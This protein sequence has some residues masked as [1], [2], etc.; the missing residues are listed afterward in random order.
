MSLQYQFTIGGVDVTSYVQQGTKI[1]RTRQNIDGNNALI[2]V[3]QNISNV[4]SLTLGLPIII[5]RGVNAV[6]EEYVFRGIIKSLKNSNYIFQL[7]CV[8]K[9]SQLKL[10]YFTKSY[11]RN[12]DTEEGVISAIFADI[13]EG[14]GFIA[15]VVD[16]SSFPK[17]NKLIC[18]D[19]SRLLKLD[20]LSTFLNWHFYHDYEND[21]IRFEP[22]NFEEYDIDLV[23]GTNI[24]S[25][26]EWD[27]GLD[28]MRN[29]IKILGA[30]DEDTRIEYFDGD[31]TAK[32]F[33]LTN[34]PLIT[35]V[36]YPID[37]LLARGIVGST[38]NYDY[39]IDSEQNTITFVNAPGTG[40]NNIKVKYTTKI[41]RPV[42]GKDD[43]SISF[44]GVTQGEVFSFSD[45]INIDD[46]ENRLQSLLSLLSITKASTGFQTT[47]IGI[48][49]G[50]LVTVEDVNQPQYNGQYTVFSSII[51][52]KSDFDAVVI[53]ERGF[54]ITR[55]MNVLSTRIKL[56]EDKDRPFIDILREIN[57]LNKIIVFKRRYMKQQKIDRSTQ[58]TNVF[59]IRHP[60]FGV[61][62]TQKL[63]DTGS[64]T[65]DVNI[66]Q[67]RNIYEEYIYDEDFYDDTS[68][69]GITWDTS[70]QEITIAGTLY[71][72]CIAL[73]TAYNYFTLSFGSS[74]GTGIISISADGK[75]TW[76]AVTENT[77]TTFTNSDGTGIYLKI[78]SA[79]GS[80]WPTA[81][82]TWGSLGS[83]LTLT[84]TYSISD[85]YVL[86][87]IKI[88]L[89][90]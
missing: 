22:L 10:D 12:I 1:D 17:L 64:I 19:E 40:T 67:G 48:K 51:N 33:T 18:K 74:T 52:Y 6:D 59:L 78:V 44:Y 43:N 77:R 72:E 50:M 26:P 16:S 76:Q 70:G 9:L 15:S 34:N 23:V 53:G 54:D 86:P 80:G 31:T 79:G 37:T 60:T 4:V 56:L 57:N 39:T 66:V 2:L 85:D 83:S 30:F 46:A 3:S 75:N 68:S 24:V 71:S 25:L 20:E 65:T 28:N 8:D 62:G 49:P 55:V 45:I 13:V 61:L 11:D 42:E 14:G 88:I 73:G 69:S 35:E 36:E 58:G 41:P 29:K 89:E 5:T 63:G 82:G 90:E 7:V 84:N 81:W 27:S 38:T 87:A 47:A 21:W 32:T